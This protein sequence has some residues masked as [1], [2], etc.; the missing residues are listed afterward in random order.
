MKENVLNDISKL[1]YTEKLIIYMVI[2]HLLEAILYILNLIETNILK[3]S[4]EEKKLY[5]VEFDQIFSVTQKISDLLYYYIYEKDL[6]DLGEIVVKE[7]KE[8][9]L[10][11]QLKP[12]TKYYKCMRELDN[13][14]SVFSSVKSI[15]DETKLK[16]IN[17]DYIISFTYGGIALGFAMRS[18]LKVNFEDYKEPIL[19]NCHYS[20]KKKLRDE[21]IGKK[22]FSFFNYVPKTYAN[23]ISKIK[24]ENN[25][26][27]LLDNNVTT[28]KT[29]DLCKNFLKQI[30]NKVYAAVVEVNYNNIHDYLLEDE[31]AEGVVQNW[32]NV[33]DFQPIGEYITAFNTW[34]TSIKS[35]LLEEIYYL[36]DIPKEVQNSINGIKENNHIFKLCR[37][38]NLFDLN[39][40]IKNGVN[41][42]GIHA[43]YPNRLQYL[44]RETKYC[45]EKNNQK[46][47]EI[48]DKLP[49]ALLEID[50][51][52]NMQK[53]IPNNVRQ[54]ILFEKLISV[55]LMQEC[56]NIYNISNESLLI[57]MQH[58]TNI[59]H[60]KEVKDKLCNRVI[61][62]IGLFQYDF[63]EYFWYIHQALNPE[64]DYILLDMS[65]HQPD[66]ISHSKKYKESIEK[67]S[68]LNRLA[69]IMSGN[70][71]PIILADDT[72]VDY[73]KRY[74]DELKLHNIKIA[75]VD[76]QNIVELSYNE[77]RYR[78]YKT[79]DDIYYGKIRKSG[80][81]LAE[82]NEFFEKIDDNM[83]GGY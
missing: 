41:M 36:E 24:H 37:V 59:E 11:K 7:L 4:E 49:I 33:L 26:I 12:F 40:A 22:G 8:I 34:N 13:N 51:I 75:G 57:Q 43:V 63:S 62:T 28:F 64:T 65:K 55:E 50:S 23:H 66:C 25:N 54:A 30:D 46:I 56:C 17:F 71:V 18:Y 53:Y 81:L 83:F 67:V 68:I 74:L 19:L 20:S 48:S 27:L 58:R 60:I 69:V 15:I 32:R 78:Q 76:M 72:D 2:D 61:I 77:Q 47:L 9:H 38:H 45:T 3:G 82:W 80:T 21:E 29:L 31:K 35:Q 79:E 44:L 42:I 10:L 1:I 16:D 52:R 6:K 14:I 39:V 70:T 5:T 73:M